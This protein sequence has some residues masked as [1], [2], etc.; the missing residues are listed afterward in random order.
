MGRGAVGA[1]IELSRVGDLASGREESIDLGIWLH[2][3]RPR[4]LPWLLMMMRLMML[5]LLQLEGRVVEALGR[6]VPA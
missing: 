5:E 2:F 6:A 1:S 4:W 3:F